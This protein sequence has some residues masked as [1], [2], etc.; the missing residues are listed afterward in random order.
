MRREYRFPGG[1]KQRLS[2]AR[3]LLPEPRILLLDD[4]LS[5][6]DAGREEEVL[7]ELGKLFRNRTVL[8][9][10]HR[11]SVFRDCNRI[12]VLKNG[13]IAEQGS[14]AELL[15]QNGLYAEMHRM[16]RLRE[17]LS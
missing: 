14:P 9:V 5:A 13:R 12:L 1:Q 6:V 8:I 3:A 15:K 4:P 11:L 7:G 16:Q 10:S 2:I 17:E